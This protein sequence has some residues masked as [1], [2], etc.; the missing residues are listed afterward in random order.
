MIDMDIFSALHKLD[1]FYLVKH[2]G[3][4]EF[5]RNLDTFERMEISHYPGHLCRNHQSRYHIRHR[6]I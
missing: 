5:F 2:L 3:M 1:F 4:Y 6:P